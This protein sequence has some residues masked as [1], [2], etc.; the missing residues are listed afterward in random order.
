VRTDTQTDARTD[1]RRQEQQ[2]YRGGNEA[3]VIWRRPHRIRGR[4]HPKKTAIRSAVF[5]QQPA[6]VD[7]NS[8]HVMF[9]MKTHRLF[10]YCIRKGAPQEPL[11]DGM[12]LIVTMLQSCV[13]I[14]IQIL[15][16]LD[17]S[18]T[19]SPDT[20]RQTCAKTVNTTSRGVYPPKTLQQVPPFPSP[21]LSSLLL[22]P[23]RS[24][25][26]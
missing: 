22:S 24:R 20:R 8:L 19:Q 17:R 16:V 11:K 14:P 9:S 6:V 12:R 13:S 23:L 21:S 2:A 5:A 4:L 15:S 3:K 26:P 10:S 7:R 1:R 25:P 18:E